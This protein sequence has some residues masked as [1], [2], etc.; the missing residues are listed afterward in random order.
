MAGLGG[1]QVS[2]SGH[3]PASVE[4]CKDGF[5][6]PWQARRARP[7]AVPVCK[8]RD[9]PLPLT[10]IT[11]NGQGARQ[12]ETQPPGH[13]GDSRAACQWVRG[14]GVAPG[15]ELHRVGNVWVCPISLFLS[16][17]CIERLP[18]RMGIRFCIGCILCAN[19]LEIC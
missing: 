13:H 14:L 6:T 19:A 9:P 11:G 7:E 8:R 18:V 16:I 3:L 2:S 15:F 1:L 17:F 5:R 10:G 4:A 12:P